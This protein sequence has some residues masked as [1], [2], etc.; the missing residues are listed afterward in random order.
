MQRRLLVTIDTEVDKGRTWRISD[1]PTFDSVTAGIPQLLSPLFDEFGVIP[2]YLLS[3]EV[4]EDPS[5][6]AVLASLGSRAELGTH[7]H[8][9]F[10]DPRR[11]LDQSNMAGALADDVQCEYDRELEAAKLRS[12]TNLFEGRFGRSPL[13]F[14]AGRFGLSRH[15]HSILAELGYTVDSSVTPGLIWRY[16]RATLDFRGWTSAPMWVDTG[17]GRLLELPVGIISGGP[18]AGLVARA[19]LTIGRGLR[20]VLGDRARHLWLRPS[21]TQGAGLIRYVERS[22]DALLVLMFHSM[23]IVPGA[24]PYAATEQ[25]VARILS[26]LRS[27]FEHCARLDIE[28]CGMSSA[29]AYA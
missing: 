11:R 12:L 7:L 25:D 4:I 10:V 29:A 27:L 19:P 24:S 15:T 26:S 1:P 2:T 22:T 23:E 5:A 20:W 3:A 6:S 8:G 9:E 13:S 17:G 18:A 21:W 14:R 16:D 28:F